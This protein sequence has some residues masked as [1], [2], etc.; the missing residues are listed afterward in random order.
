MK[1][2]FHLNTRIYPILIATALLNFAG[3]QAASWKN[4]I[5]VWGGD[6]KSFRPDLDQART[7][8]V[9]TV[10]PLGRDKYDVIVVGGG[11]AGLNAALYLSDHKKRVLLL[12]KEDHFGGL[13][14][15][16]LDSNGLSYDR[17]AA[18]FTRTYE[19]EQKFLQNMGLGGYEKYAIPEPI[20]SYL[21]VVKNP[22]GKTEYQFFPGIWEEETLKNLEASFSVFKFELIRANF[23]LKQIPNQPIEEF[24]NKFL[25]TMSATDWIRQMPEKMGAWLREASHKT[26]EEMELSDADQDLWDHQKE[27]S[28]EVYDRFQKEFG[29]KTDPMKDVIDLMELYCRS[30]LGAT[31]D[32]VSAIAFANFYISEIETRFTTDMGTGKA[33]ELMVNK[34]RDNRHQISKGSYFSDL[35]QSSPVGKIIRK[36][37]EVE[38]QFLKLSSDKDRED[39]KKI[40]YHVEPKLYKAT[41]DYVVFAAQLAVA[42]Y[43][44][45]GFDDQSSDPLVKEKID[46]ISRLDYAH[47]SVHAVE[48]KGFPYRA[49]YDTWTRSQFDYGE[50]DFTDVI[51][52]YWVNKKIIDPEK[53]ETKKK[54]FEN[55]VNFKTDPEIDGKKIPTSILTIY[56]PLPPSEVKRGKE[57][58]KGYDDKTAKTY[59]ETAVNRMIEIYSPF[60]K[61][62]YK[63][64]LGVLSV[65]TNRWPY[66]V[67]IPSPGH[68][69]NNVKT[70][71][72]PLGRI[73]FANNNL[74]TPAFEEALFRGHCAAANVLFKMGVFKPKKEYP[75]NDNE[76]PWFT[77]PQEE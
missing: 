67:H 7:W 14:A 72:K 53:D 58:G 13:A 11:L 30:A 57:M 6:E 71:R 77:C 5:K 49:T 76:N 3:D 34:M 16:T 27:I 51:L 8:P 18:Y 64:E 36:E 23:E 73:Y 61:E 54:E 44:I 10:K 2:I 41:A 33:A 28:K 20:D 74:G 70:L 38:V 32:K 43:L 63:T 22:Q 55:F 47:Y 75:E 65:N 46:K 9:E 29:G 48:V 56:H 59:A 17:G 37:N 21:R 26:D 19:E 42:P 15:S 45:E 66:S 12:E 68:F 31:P 69:S 35:R 60:L 1:N 40:V 62:K 50:K 39:S 52:G 4:N 24:D 25:D